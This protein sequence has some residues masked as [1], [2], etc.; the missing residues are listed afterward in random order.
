ME[1]YKVMSMDQVD[2]YEEVHVD[3]KVFSKCSLAI[4][5]MNK[6]IKE[7][8]DNESDLKEGSIERGNSFYNWDLDGEINYF[9]VW[10]DITELDDLNE[11]QDRPAEGS[12]LDI[13]E[14]EKKSFE[15]EKSRPKVIWPGLEGG[16]I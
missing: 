9:Y 2:A 5:Y 12:I 1:L 16:E 13:L 7:F 3:C 15:D 8:E 4:E 11:R 14:Q 6:L 10:I